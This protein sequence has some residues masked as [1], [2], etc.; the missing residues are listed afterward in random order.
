MLG[1]FLKRARVAAALASSI[2]GLV[3]VV[4]WFIARKTGYVELH[5][6]YVGLL[7]GLGVYLLVMMC[8]KNEDTETGRAEHVLP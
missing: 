2:S 3:A 5:E 1:L 7:V 4:G 6:V 8:E